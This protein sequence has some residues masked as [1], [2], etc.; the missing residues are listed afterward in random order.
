MCLFNTAYCPL[1]SSIVHHGLT[2][3]HFPNTFLQLGETTQKDKKR[4]WK[5]Q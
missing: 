2:L 1:L 5:K 3:T 4:K